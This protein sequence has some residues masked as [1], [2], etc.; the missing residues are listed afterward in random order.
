MKGKR[1]FLLF[2]LSRDDAY[3]SVLARAVDESGQAWC[4]S[5]RL[6]EQVVRLSPA[7]VVA[8]ATQEFCQRNNHHDYL[9][10]D[11]AS[12]PPGRMW[13]PAWAEGV[14]LLLLNTRGK[15]QAVRSVSN[16]FGGILS[17][18]GSALDHLRVNTGEYQ[19]IVLD[20]VAGQGFDGD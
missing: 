5:D 15:R 2:V 3:M 20:R 6:E 7:R 14:P 10:F 19:A 8:V 17:C 4:Y 13:R 12:V 9:D 11:K 18:M 1:P 16:C